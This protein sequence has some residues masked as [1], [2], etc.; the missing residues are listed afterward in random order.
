M[1]PAPVGSSTTLAP[2]ASPVITPGPPPPPVTF[3]EL[4]PLSFQKGAPLKLQPIAKYVY[5]FYALSPDAKS[6]VSSNASAQDGKRPI[7]SGTRLFTPSF[8]DGV[9]IEAHV[10]TA[11]F[12]PDG[13]RVLVW[14]FGNGDLAVLEVATGKTLYRREGAVCAARF[15][16]PDQVVFHESSK[17]PDARLWRVQISTGQTTPLGAPRV[18]DFCEASA[19]GSAWVAHLD[20]T[21]VFVDGKTGATLAIQPPKDANVVLAAGATRYCLPSP[22]GLSCVRLPGGGVEQIWSRPTSESMT[23]SP[24]GEHA[25][26]T[27]VAKPDGIYDSFAWIDFAAKTVRSLN[28]FRGYSGSL[29]ALHPQ[30]KLISIGSGNGLH[31]YDVERGKVRFAAHRPLYENRVDP[32][33]SRRVLIGTDNVKD[34]FYVDV[35]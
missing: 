22:S 33:L 35:P 16:G 18:S 3:S 24:D 29:F 23:F 13:S 6:W 32:N 7:D 15:D 12:L 5:D 4:P 25:L 9:G 34:E 27:Y 2:S 31:V 21:R 17:D 8:P 26:V 30:G 20:D 28:G 1:G 10:P 11:R 14:S 19:D